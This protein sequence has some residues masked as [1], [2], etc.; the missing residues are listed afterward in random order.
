M[1]IAARTDANQAEIV[2]A[3]RD[4]GFSVQLLHRVGQGCPDLLVG[5]PWSNVLL[6]VKT[7]KGELTV[8]EREFLAHWRGPWAIVRT[9]QEAMEAMEWARSSSTP[10][11]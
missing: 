9:V 3:L 2:R 5:Q 10:K 11:W 7:A 4:A 8:D 6:E 1:R